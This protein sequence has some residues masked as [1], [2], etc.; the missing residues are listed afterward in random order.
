MFSRNR[1]SKPE[2]TPEELRE[3]TQD[4]LHTMAVSG[5][6]YLP[7]LGVSHRPSTCKARPRALVASGAASAEI[8][9]QGGR[10]GSVGKVAAGELIAGPARS[11]SA[12]AAR[13]A[14]PPWP[15]ATGGLK[16]TE[17]KGAERAYRFA[18]LFNQLAAQARQAAS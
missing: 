9:G 5:R 14:R 18:E 2:P 10:R 6:V 7:G 16:L 15:S 1:T 4:R 17:V 8:A 11:S 13:R 12:P 3:K